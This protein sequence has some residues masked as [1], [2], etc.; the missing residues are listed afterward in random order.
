MLVDKKDT[1]DIGWWK[2]SLK[3]DNGWLVDLFLNFTLQ[4]ANV[5]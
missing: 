5:L 2:G 1:K 3:Q 4:I